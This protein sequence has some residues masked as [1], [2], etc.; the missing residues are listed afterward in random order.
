M[1][2]PRLL[3]ARHDRAAG[4]LTL[5]LDGAAAEPI[6]VAR[7]SDT[8]SS[9]P[10]LRIITQRGAFGTTVLPHA[11]DRHGRFSIR[12]AG[13]WVAVPDVYLAEPVA[14]IGDAPHAVSITLRSAVIAEA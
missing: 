4:T 5:T 12:I 1:P 8:R 13:A 9:G 7:V 2:Q 6:P 3:T 11:G 14:I 10:V